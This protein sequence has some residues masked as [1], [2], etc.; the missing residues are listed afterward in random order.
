MAVMVEAEEEEKDVSEVRA[1][2]EEGRRKKEVGKRKEKKRRRRC[3]DR[4]RKNKSL[5][6]C[7]LLALFR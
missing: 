3:G 2:A 4:W 7:H 6:F 5:S 1:G